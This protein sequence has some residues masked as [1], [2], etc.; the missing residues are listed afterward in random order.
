MGLIS[1]LIEVRRKAKVRRAL[2]ATLKPDPGYRERRLSQFTPERRKRYE[3]N[4][5]DAGL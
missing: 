4:V 3:R 2:E 1:D 5:R